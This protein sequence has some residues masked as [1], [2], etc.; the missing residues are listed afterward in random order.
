MPSGGPAWGG[1]TGLIGT[2]GSETGWSKKENCE[3]EKGG[4]KC[5]CGELG[6]GEKEKKKDMD[7]KKEKEGMEEKEE[8][9]G[10]PGLW[11]PCH[12]CGRKSERGS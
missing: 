7:E 10:Y 6:R 2:R 1:D 11:T 12:P 4:G 3:R 9:V 8:T 5:K